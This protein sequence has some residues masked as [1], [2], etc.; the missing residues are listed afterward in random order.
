MKGGSD[1]PQ[2]EVIRNP[3]RTTGRRGSG[4]SIERRPHVIVV[5]NEKGGC[6][7][8][9]CALHLV[10]AL[11][12]EGYRVGALDL[13]TRQATLA[14]C[15]AARTTFAQVH[16]LAL[17]LPERASVASARHDTRA[18]AEAE[19]AARFA[20]AMAALAGCEIV[21]VDCPGTD[22]FLSRLG[23]AHADT[24]ITPINDSFVDFAVLA[25]LD[26]ITHAVGRPGLYSEMVWEARKRRF[27]RDRGQ[28][29]WI[30]MRNRVAG[31]RR[32]HGPQDVGAALEGLSK[33]IGFR[34]LRG[35]GDRG[36]FRERFV[37]GLTLLDGEDPALGLWPGMGHVAARAELRALL[38]AIRRRP[39][40]Q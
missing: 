31:G 8:S 27:A 14:A 5:G 33:R 13:D 16:E 6:G 23:H 35:F 20:A 38:G 3:A 4:V 30:V 10:V 21:V 40:R 36:V 2:A 9:L 17:P 19:E 37:Q 26:P 7:K 34:T 39:P 25:E 28:I 22:N 24:L 32:R 1:L 11:L 12:R 15:L 29:D 18:E